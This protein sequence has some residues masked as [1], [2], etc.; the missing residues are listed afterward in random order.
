MVLIHTV[1]GNNRS[2]SRE[3]LHAMHQHN[4]PVAQGVVDE[5]ARRRQIYEQVGIVDV[6]DGYAKMLNA[7][8][9]IVCGDRFPTERH[10]M[11]DTPVGKRAGRDSSIE[12]IKHWSERGASL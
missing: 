4:S 1:R 7:G 3:S 8:C 11:G 10:D 12:A 2:T 9:R 5:L 6:L